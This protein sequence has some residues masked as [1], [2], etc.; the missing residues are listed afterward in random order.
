MQLSVQ[1]KTSNLHAF[2]MST[3]GNNCHSAKQPD[4]AAITTSMKRNWL[5]M[6]IFFVVLIAIAFTIPYAVS[7]SKNTTKDILRS[8]CAVRWRHLL[9]QYT[10]AV[11]QL[12]DAS[13]QPASSAQSVDAYRRKL[14]K[15]ENEIVEA[16]K[17]TTLNNYVTNLFGQ[18]FVRSANYAERLANLL[19]SN[20]SRNMIDTEFRRWNETMQDLASVM[21]GLAADPSASVAANTPLFSSATSSAAL[22]KNATMPLQPSQIIPIPQNKELLV[23]W[24]LAMDQ[25]VEYSAKKQYEAAQYAFE[26]AFVTSQ[27]LADL[28]ALTLCAREPSY[29]NF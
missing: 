2:A 15:T 21:G 4:C 8:P 24:T 17:G 27:Q 1:M 23:R 11:R 28:W 5:T 29:D 19:K 3:I 7:V 12:V 26:E 6:L 10:I 13:L 20:S 18:H 22:Y 9:G 25:F 14:Q 16:Y